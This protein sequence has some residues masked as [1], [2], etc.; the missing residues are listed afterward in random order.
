MKVP[1]FHRAGAGGSS[2][3]LKEHFFR[4]TLLAA[5]LLLLAGGVAFF[6]R[7]G[8]V[9]QKISSGNGSIF[10]NIIKSV[11]GVEAKLKGEDSGR[12][13]ILLLGMRGEKLTGGGLL[14]DTIMVLSIHPSGGEG[15][16]PRASFVSVPRDLYVTVPDTAEKRKI[17]AVYALGEEKGRGKGMEN[18]KRIVGDV[19]GQPIE[20]ALAINFQGFV[21][22]VNAVGGVTVHL[23]RPF[24]EG[25]Q[26]RG[27]EQRCDLTTYTIPSGNVEV[28]KGTRSNGSVYYRHYDL[29]F[30]KMTP[31]VTADLECGGDFKLPAGDN[32]LDGEK[33]L[34]YVRARY[35]TSDFDRARRQQ[36][37]VQLVKA[38]A[39]SVGTLTDFGKLQ[40]LMDALGENFRTD[41]EGWEMKRFFDL[42]QKLGS[43]PKLT[44]KVLEDSEEGLLYAPAVTKEAGYIL[45]PRGD[46]YD[47]IKALF[48]SLP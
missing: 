44:Q 4:R 27:L 40:S 47:R 1:F 48:Q 30:E 23:D 34:C 25:I 46:N 6:F 32:T 11:P 16:A 17:N 18:M 29:C 24:E 28:K 9:L 45:L 13:N 33:A 14:A 20:Y 22:L 2:A 39:F 3:P 36:E 43:E 35:G 26:F 21:D 42:Y 8:N 19:T 38:K 15:D 41:M 31:A 10:E 12:I 7:A 37:I 5:F